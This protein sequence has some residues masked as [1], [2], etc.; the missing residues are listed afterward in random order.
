MILSTRTIQQPIRL[1]ASLQNEHRLS[2]IEDRRP[3]FLGSNL[4]I[5]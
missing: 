3:N 5:Y 1:G 4:L 2:H